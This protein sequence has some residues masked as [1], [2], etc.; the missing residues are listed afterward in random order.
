[1]MKVLVTGASGNG[2]Q[3]VCRALLDAGYTVRMADVIPTQMD[4]LKQAEFV[5]CDTRTPADVR[6]AVA[7]MDAVVHLAAWHCAHNPPV[8]DETIFAVNVDGTFHVLEACRQEGIQ[9][10]VYASSMAYGWWSVYGV[11]KVIGEDLCKAY[12]EMTGAS[13]V[14]LRYH[15]FIPRPYL[16]FGARLLKNGVDRRDVAAATVASVKAV[17]ARRVGLFR[18]IVHT[19]HG[20][21]QEVV[22][23]FRELGV[24]WC[25]EHVP[26]ARR[27]IEKYA[28][29]LPEQVEQH[30][31]KE[32]EQVL[33]WRPAVGFLDFLRDLQ[34]RDEKGLDVSG[35]WV[36]SELPGMWPAR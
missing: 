3:A 25:E 33:G 31:L 32:A 2:G 9:S 13:I 24:A 5:R 8:S 11:S 34:A 35:L 29:P 15:E 26:G 23:R 16:E 10:I 17:L 19:D 36:P 1:M 27:L 22:D 28:I 21:P 7:G 12:N 20:M 4:D 30:D 18:T 6:R 14:M